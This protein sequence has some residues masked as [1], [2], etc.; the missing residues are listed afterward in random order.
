MDGGLGETAEPSA[1]IDAYPALHRAI[2]EAS[3]NLTRGLVVDS[4]S[5]LGH[6]I[7][8]INVRGACKQ[9][10]IETTSGFVRQS[11]TG[12]PPGRSGEFMI[13]DEAPER[14]GLEY[15]YS[16]WGLRARREVARSDRSLGFPCGGNFG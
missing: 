7:R 1:T 16:L 14:A 13:G 3:G 2:A 15:R 6:A 4:L 10:A 11:R 9:V 12:A 5:D 8:P